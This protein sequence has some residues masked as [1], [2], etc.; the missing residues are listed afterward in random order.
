[1]ENVENVAIPSV[2]ECFVFPLNSDGYL[3]DPRCQERYCTYLD[4][5]P[6]FCAVAVLKVSQEARLIITRSK[7]SFTCGRNKKR[8]ALEMSCHY[9]EV[10]AVINFCGAIGSIWELLSLARGSKRPM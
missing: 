8:K 10:D 3:R 6:T 7:G 5:I 2:G 9:T 4:T 1:M